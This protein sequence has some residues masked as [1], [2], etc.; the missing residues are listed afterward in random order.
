MIHCAACWILAVTMTMMATVSRKA[1]CDDGG[2]EREVINFSNG[3][4][5]SYVPV[6]RS[7]PNL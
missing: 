3:T 6:P 1:R 2:G 7:C 5:S 4:C